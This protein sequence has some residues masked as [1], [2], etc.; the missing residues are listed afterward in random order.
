VYDLK[1]TSAVRKDLKKL[2]PP[3]RQVIREEHL[4]RIQ[5]DPE[6]GEP[7]LHTFKGLWSY[8]FS[9]GGVGYRIIYEIDYQHQVVILMLIDSRERLYQQLR[10][11]VGS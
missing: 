10:R 8:H 2:D 7:L 5:A 11:R 9:Q 4:P 1:T 6:I 3:V